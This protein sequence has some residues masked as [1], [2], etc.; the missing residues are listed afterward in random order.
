VL[1]RNAS[2]NPRQP[3]AKANRAIAAA[4]HHSLLSM[5]GDFCA[6]MTFPNLKSKRADSL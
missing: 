5:P 2:Q 1:L 3:R 6:A 4:T